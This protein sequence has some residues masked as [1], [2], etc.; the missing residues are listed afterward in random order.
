MILPDDGTELQ[1]ATAGEVVCA[2]RDLVLTAGNTKIT[3]F[4]PRFAG[5]GNENSLCVLFDTE[6]CDILIMGDRNAFGER[7]LLRNSYVP[8]V[9][10]LIVGHHGSKSSTCQEL[11]DAVKPEIAC[12]SVSIDNPY[13]HPSQEVLQRLE[14]FG[15]RVY[16]TD[17]DGE[18][19]IRR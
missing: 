10:V 15:C 1:N 16:R 5:T 8:D 6:K 13:G 2:A 12:I 14:D 17:L 3:V 18:I 19:V 11:L 4:V 7:S 9:D